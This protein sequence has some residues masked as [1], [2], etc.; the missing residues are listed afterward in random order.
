MESS[1]ERLL[2]FQGVRSKGRPSIQH[3]IVTSSSTRLLQ[4]GSRKIAGDNMAQALSCE[5]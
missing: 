1:T 4:N 2:A 5:V 3:G